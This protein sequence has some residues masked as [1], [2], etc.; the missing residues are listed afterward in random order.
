MSRPFLY[1]SLLT[2]THVRCLASLSYRTLARVHISLNRFTDI[3]QAFQNDS[4]TQERG[5]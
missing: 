5:L 4:E 1:F 2:R 3:V